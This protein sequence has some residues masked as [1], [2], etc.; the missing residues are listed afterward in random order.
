VLRVADLRSRADRLSACDESLS[1]IAA[2]VEQLTKE[3]DRVRAGASPLVQSLAER[4]TL[5]T[6]KELELTRLEN[7]RLLAQRRGEDATAALRETRDLLEEHDGRVTNA[8]RELDDLRSTLAERDALLTEKELELT[9]LENERL[10]ALR[11]A[12]DATAAL[13]ETRELFDEHANSIATSTRGLEELRTRLAERDRQLEEAERERSRLDKALEEERAAVA[14]LRVRAKSTVDAVDD[15]AAAR[16]HVLF[17]PFPEGY[18]LVVSDKPCPRP[19]EVV[20][21]EGHSFV[22]ARVGR[23]PFPADDRSCA[24]LQLR[25]TAI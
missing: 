1:L 22:V 11:G 17:A 24:F 21:A 19:G 20:D 12:E 25:I 18:R 5:L 15:R 13:H 9:R 2:D 4:D 8:T 16:G 23:S 3:L 14:D 10:Q 6:E 7:E